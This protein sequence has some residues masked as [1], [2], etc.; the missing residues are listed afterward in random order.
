M[1]PKVNKNQRDEDNGDNEEQSKRFK[2]SLSLEAMNSKVCAV[3]SDVTELKLDIKEIKTSIQ[4]MSASV[5]VANDNMKTELTTALSKIT[6]TL[7]GLVTQVNNLNEK[8]KEKEVKINEMDR[9]INSL[10]QQLLNNSIEI[11]NIQNKNMSA[12]D[13]VKTIAANVNVEITEDDISNAYSLKRDDTKII[14][15]FSSINRKR[16][17]MSNITRHRV[18]GNIINETSSANTE[19][20]NNNNNFIYVNDL[21][22]PYNRRLLWLAKSKA[23]ECKWDFVWF[24]NGLILA[25]KKTKNLHQF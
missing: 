23:K 25:K 5:G 9:R 12:N 14:V 10:E 15:E 17:I 3:Q 19:S 20:Q 22:T 2:D 1:P 4:K 8:N 24:R 6:E 16:Q 21:L 13:V 7:T 11:K 18:E